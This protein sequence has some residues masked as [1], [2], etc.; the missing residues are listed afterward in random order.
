M[1]ASFQRVPWRSLKPNSSGPNPMEKTSTRTPHQRATRKWPSSWK[2]TTIVKNEQERDRSSPSAPATPEHRTV[3]KVH[4]PRSRLPCSPARAGFP[5]MPLRQFRARGPRANDLALWSM[6]SASSTLVGLCVSPRLAAAAS[7]VAST[8]AANPGK[9]QPAGQKCRDRDLVGGIEHGRR[10]AARLE[11]PRGPAPAPGKR[12]RSGCSKVRLPM[13]ARSSRG[14][15]PSIRS[16]QARQ[17]AIGMRMSGRPSC[18][19]TEPSR[20]STRPCTIDCGCTSTSISSGG[21]REQMMR[22]DHFQALVH[23]RR[24]IDGD[25][26]A[27]RPVRMLQRLFGRGRPDRLQR[28]GAERAARGGQD[29][30]PHVLAAAGAQRLEQRVVLGIDRQ[31]GRAGRSPRGA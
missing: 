1:A 29:H 21:E 12:T 14:A 28:P 17:W 4:I 5:R 16:G 11:R 26:R 24:G 19:I 9:A 7:S 13:L 8:R 18:A 15:G 6:A 25:L 10:R 27:H 22:L 23:Q 20:N 30:A 2:N 3:D 31:D